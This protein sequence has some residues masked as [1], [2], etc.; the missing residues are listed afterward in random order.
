MN[1]RY[2]CR[3]FSPQLAGW[4]RIGHFREDCVRV[5]HK[6]FKST[7][8]SWDSMCEEAAKFASSIGKERLINIS[9]TGEQGGQG[10]VFVWY[11]D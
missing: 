4:D 6:L 3:S 8:K 9:V 1:P 7:F 10:V 5:Q 2:P 11:W